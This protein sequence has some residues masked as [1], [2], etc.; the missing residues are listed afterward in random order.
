MG[1][2]P[3]G[4]RAIPDPYVHLGRPRARRSLEQAGGHLT[5]TQ[6]ARRP[7]TTRTASDGHWNQISPP[8]RHSTD[9]GAEAPQAEARATLA[10]SVS[11]IVATDRHARAGVRATG[12]M[13]MNGAAADILI[14]GWS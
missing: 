14:R 4:R 2:S 3:N 6:A 13:R 10:A 7:N 8:V 12:R 11:L 9:P 5:R 1:R